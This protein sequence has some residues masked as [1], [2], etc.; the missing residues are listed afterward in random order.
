VSTEPGQ[1][2]LKAATGDAGANLALGAGSHALPAGSA[3]A[4]L[5]VV[6]GTVE[7]SH[8]SRMTTIA[9]DSGRLPKACCAVPFLGFA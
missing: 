5:M 9:D 1:L 8:A 6:T 2:Q 7:V 3:I 4:P